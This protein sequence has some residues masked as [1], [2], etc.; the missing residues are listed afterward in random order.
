MNVSDH[1]NRTNTITETPLSVHFLTESAYQAAQAFIASGTAANT[2]RSYR[3]ALTY[4]SAWLHLRFGI[5]LGD[6]SLPDTVVMQFVLDHLARPLPDGGWAH[7]LPPTVD[8]ALVNAKA[9]SKAGALAFNT[10]SHRLAVLSKWHQINQWP[11]PT[12]SSEV[13]IL[14]REARKAQ[15]RQGIQVRK[16]TA[17]VLEPLQAL[18][19][20]CTDGIRGVRDRALLLLAWSGGGRRRS[21]VVGL[22][23]TDVRQ[24]DDDT[25]LYALGTTKTDTG[26][27]RR[28]KL[29]RGPAARALG[30]WLAAAP[31][32]SG[33]L[34]RR[35][36]KG[37]KVGIR[38]LSA[39]QIARIVQRRAALAGL[40]GDWAAHSL[41]SGFVTEAGRQD[42]PLGQ[43]MAMTEHHSVGTVMGYFQAGSLLE[44]K[45]TQLLSQLDTSG[46]DAVDVPDSGEQEPHQ[47]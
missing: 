44:S 47:P 45:A 40:D 22:R 7:M 24:L 20:T 2:V 29:L 35:M 27:M 41:R 3:S 34:F 25:W 42:V 46:V 43:V 13:K 28:E 23:V 5:A 1:T 17:L 31:A 21:E 6:G 18:L 37:N 33:P 11:S 38:A 14:L 15:S 4:W 32:T 8:M 39:D 36:Y 19:A 30:A 26:G 12:E 16:K 9:K 10:V